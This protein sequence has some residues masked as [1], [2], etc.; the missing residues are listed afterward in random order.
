VRQFKINLHKRA[1]ENLRLLLII[2]V[3]IFL[4]F[5]L[6]TMLR[7]HPERFSDGSLDLTQE[8]ASPQKLIPLSG[9]WE[10]YYGVLL[11]SS[12]FESGKALANKDFIKVP[13]SWDESSMNSSRKGIATYR[14]MIQY[15]ST[16][17]DP[18][19]RITG[20]STAYKLFVNGQLITTI[21]PF[22]NVET[23]RN[24]GTEV[25]IVSLPKDSQTAEIIIQ[26]SNQKY[27]KGGLRES[28]IFGSKSVLEEKRNRLM[29]LQL[30]FI[31]S[32]FIFGVHYL[33]LFL[34]HRKDW[35]SLIF[36]LICF[37]SGIRSLIWGEIPVLIFSPDIKYNTLAYINYFTGYN[38]IPLMLIFIALIYPLD[39]KKRSL[40][41]IL[42]PTLFFNALLFTTTYFMS[43]FTKYLYPVIII[44]MVYML[45]ILIRSVLNNRE[46]ALFMFITIS[47]YILTINQDI[48]HYNGIGGVNANS[49][50]L[51]GNTVVIIALSF[52]Q[53]KHQSKTQQ[54]LKLYNENLLEADRLKDKIME[55]EMSFLQAQIK[56]HFLYN[57][58]NAIANISEK[59]GQ[60]AGKLI[61]DLAIYLRESLAFNN[62]EKRVSL[63]KEIEFVDK[64]FSIEHA[65][66]GDK[67]KLEKNINCPLTFQIPVLILQPLVENAVRHGISKKA[68]GG[69]VRLNIEMTEH[70]TVFEIIDDG[71]G[72]K[73]EILLDLLTEN[74]P[75]QGIGLLNINS[76]LKR[77]YNSELK[78]TSELNQGTTV[79]FSILRSKDK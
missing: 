75:E 44:Q 79:H 49:M 77:I 47:L 19:I 12:D 4:I 48:L 17:Q 46:N 14:L 50:F 78:I 28:P 33:L 25:V 23:N 10:F 72:I 74:N 16:I 20:V 56:P 18:A 34:L 45:I 76:R 6:V 57:A 36:S 53:A 65:R 26:V 62:L 8:G 21:G 64:Y 22:E 13:G 32:V 71:V 42:L 30:L 1:N 66:F 27:A 63:E 9:E 60:E 31:G 38:I 59:N 37:T 55:T 24:E 7:W 5:S 61:I 3:V 41:L 68:G 73:P 58:L 67:I 52:L 11:D 2:S 39:F 43:Y 40:V 35:V 51:Y 29:A 54:K 70:E 15:P 69:L